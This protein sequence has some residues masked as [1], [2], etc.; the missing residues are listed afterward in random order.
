MPPTD[1]RFE[2]QQIHILR[3]YNNQL[4][5]HFVVRDDMGMMLQ[6]GMISAPQQG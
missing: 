6:L 2:Q 4:T 5:E 1:R 3:V